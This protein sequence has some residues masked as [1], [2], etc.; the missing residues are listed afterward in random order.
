MVENYKISNVKSQE[1]DMLEKAPED[2][3]GHSDEHSTTIFR[4]EAQNA[5]DEIPGVNCTLVTDGIFSYIVYAGFNPLQDK[6]KDLIYN[7]DFLRYF[8]NVNNYI[9][10]Q[11]NLSGGH[12]AVSLKRD[13]L[14]TKTT[15][16][17]LNSPFLIVV[18]KITGSD[19][20]HPYITINAEQLG[21]EGDIVDILSPCIEQYVEDEAE[22]G[23]EA[24]THTRLSFNKGIQ[25]R[26]KEYSMLKTF[27]VTEFQLV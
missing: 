15:S 5:D 25:S 14:I 20:D 24:V 17:Y 22:E 27:E 19:N 26:K 3:I 21:V 11:A 13:P 7:G 16:P 23:K 9:P 6:E 1:W 10:V 2:V 18:Y 12:I 8:H 4:C